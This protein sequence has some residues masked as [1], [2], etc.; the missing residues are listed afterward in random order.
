MEPIGSIGHDAAV[1][2]QS[3]GG[4]LSA[5]VGSGPIGFLGFLSMLALI[6]FAIAAIITALPRSV[7]RRN[8]YPFYAFGHVQFLLFTLTNGFCGILGFHG[9]PSA[10]GQ[11]A[12]ACSDLSMVLTP[13]WLN[14]FILVFSVAILGF[15]TRKWPLP[16]KCAV[17]SMLLVLFDLA[18]VCG[19]ILALVAQ[20][21]IQE[22][23]DQQDGGR[24]SFE[25]APSAPSNE[26]SP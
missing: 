2:V 18:L 17:P 7:S 8:P 1:V 3:S 26:S 4:I 23:R 9:C 21:E 20:G 11:L 25:V 10:N 16:P 24:I 6:L 12:G 13:I 19:V 15:I 22:M 14:L 5:I